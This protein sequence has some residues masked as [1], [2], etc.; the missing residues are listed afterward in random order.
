MGAA[1]TGVDVV[2]TTGDQRGT[3]SPD[4]LTAPLSHQPGG[5]RCVSTW[6]GRRCPSGAL[7][8][9]PSSPPLPLSLPPFP[10]SF[11]VSSD[12]L[13]LSLPFFCAFKFAPVYPPIRSAF[14]P[15]LTLHPLTGAS[16]RSALINTQLSV[17]PPHAPTAALL[18]GHAGPRCTCPGLLDCSLWWAVT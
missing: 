18:G 14:L 17:C 11:P 12:F 4:V 8:A 6:G 1:G 13:F 3:Q 2:R 10:C 7:S 15:A 16:E 9:S 5:G